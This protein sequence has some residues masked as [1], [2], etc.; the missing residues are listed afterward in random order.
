MSTAEEHNPQRGHRPNRRFVLN[1]S[2]KLLSR[3]IPWHVGLAI[4]EPISRLADPPERLIEPYVRKGQTVADLGCG[5][6][7]YTLALAELVGPEGKVY[8]VDLDKKNIR[9]VQKRADKGNYR[10]IEAHAS[11]ASDLSFIKDK[12]IDFILA[13]GLL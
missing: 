8:A 6:G 5:R 10:N 12:S 4:V 3:I 7:Y 11:S 2:G 1:P 9:T 13:N